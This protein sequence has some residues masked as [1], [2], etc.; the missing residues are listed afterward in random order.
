MDH[1]TCLAGT[2]AINLAGK[3]APLYALDPKTIHT[4]H[5]SNHRIF[6]NSLDFSDAVKDFKDGLRFRNHTFYASLDHPKFSTYGF[7]ANYTPNVVENKSWLEYTFNLGK[8]LQAR[9]ISG[10]SFRHASVT[11]GEERTLYQVIDR[12]DLSVGA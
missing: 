4:T 2:P 3:Q 8:W 10:F 9:T 5:L 11:A 6:I 12:R 1:G 7:G